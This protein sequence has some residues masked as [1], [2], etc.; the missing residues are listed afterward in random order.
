M[1]MKTII[2]CFAFSAVAL[3]AEAQ[4]QLKSGLSMDYFDTSVNPATNFYE[5]ANRGWM[6][7]NPLPAAYSR[8]GTFDQLQENNTKR[9]NAII[10]E[11]SKNTYPKGSV[12]QKLSDLYKMAMDSDRQNR[13]GVLPVKK[14]LD[15]INQAKTLEE[16]RNIQYKNE[17]FGLMQFFVMYFAPDDKNASQN[18]MSISQ[19]GLTLEQKEYYLDNDPETVKIREAFKKHIVK[20]FRLYGYGAK[21]AKGYMNEIMSVETALA[22]ISKS[23][24][25]L[26]DVEANYNKMSLKQMETLYPHLEWIKLF[27]GYGADLKYCQDILVGQPSFL[28]GTDA[29]VANMKPH[30]LKALLIWDMICASADY[31]GDQVSAA[32]FEF[33]GTVMHGKKSDFPRWKKSVQMLD[34][35]MGEALGKMYVE[36]YFPAS[37]KERMVKLVRNLQ[38]SLADRIQAQAWMSDK[39]KVNALN[40]LLHFYVK[41]GY[42]DKWKD[43]SALTINTDD[44]YFENKL[45]INEYKLKDAINRTQGKPVNREEWHMTPQ[46]VNAYYNPVTNE[47]CFPAGILQRPFFDPEADDAFNYGAIGVVIGH[48]MTHGFDDQGCHYDAYGNMND[49]WTEEDKKQFNERAK[50][51]GDFFSKINVLPDLKANGYLTLGENLADHGGLQVAFNALEKATKNNSL[52]VID[53]LTPEQRFFVAYA[54]VWAAN[55]TDLEIRS[56]TKS[57]PHALGYW[58]VNGT[59]PHIDGWYQSFNVKEGDKMFI[60]KDKRLDLW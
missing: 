59:L 47:I 58:R 49:W 48:E 25:E 2:S 32:N 54:N 44:S 21:D 35:S 19:G 17:K 39:T 5:Y 36:R 6:K 3:G 56:R 57:D 38:L 55:I 31:V 14:Y 60:S 28:K 11:L 42:P 50:V 23:N 53:G 40:K 30:T 1:K 52:P 34:G 12:E 33:F 29:I 26:R 8:Y 51:L 15:E 13:E 37:S 9:I 20:M 46:T 10:E 22:K 24:T 43:Y 41:I 27:E 18:I 45:R 16:L 4:G 7:S